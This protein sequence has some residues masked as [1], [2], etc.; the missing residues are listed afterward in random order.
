VREFTA[1]EQYTVL[2]ERWYG[3]PRHF[4]TEGRVAATVGA[5]LAGA[6]LVALALHYHLTLR[7]NDRLAAALDDSRR[8]TAS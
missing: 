2:V 8:K 4:W 1:S 7:L 6:I 3:K 5:V